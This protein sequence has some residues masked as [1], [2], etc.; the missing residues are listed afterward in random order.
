MSYWPKTA[1]QYTAWL[2]I[3]HKNRLFQK[4]RL[5][6]LW[7][8]CYH[9][10]ANASQITS[11][12]P[13]FFFKLGWCQQQMVKGNFVS[14]IGTDLTFVPQRP[15][16]GSRDGETSLNL[17]KLVTEVALG[18]LLLCGGNSFLKQWWTHW[19]SREKWSC[20]CSCTRSFFLVHYYSVILQ[21]LQSSSIVS[22]CVSVAAIAQGA[23][24]LNWLNR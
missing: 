21:S 20:P 7:D 15:I 9:A 19:S 4:E 2:D 10:S 3:P 24:A 11:A 14:Q 22:A 18:Q 17:E 5:W 13:F 6:L 16:W 12:A 23:I 1:Q 8:C